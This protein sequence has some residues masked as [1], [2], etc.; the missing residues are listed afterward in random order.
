MSQFEPIA[1][2]GCGKYGNNGLFSSSSFDHIAMT[3][4]H[5]ELLRKAA[6]YSLSKKT[7]SS[8][9]TVG[10][11]LGKCESETNAG[12]SLPISENTDLHHVADRRRP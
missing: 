9:K 6:K 2:S 12:T 3:S 5:K 8:Y 1:E 10:N 7:W 4:S 11:L